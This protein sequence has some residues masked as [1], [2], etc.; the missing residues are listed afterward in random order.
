MMR[1]LMEA[2]S[3]RFLALVVA[4]AAPAALADNKAPDK[5]KVPAPAAPVTAPAPQA[6][7]PVLPPIEALP[8]HGKSLPQLGIYRLI[9]PGQNDDPSLRSIEDVFLS[10]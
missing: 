9:T 7:A 4:L 3:M 5:K 2:N 8:A 1:A 6:P 10:V